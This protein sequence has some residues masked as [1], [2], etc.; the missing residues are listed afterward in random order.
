MCM[1]WSRSCSLRHVLAWAAQVIRAKAT[2]TGNLWPV[3]SHPKSSD[4]GRRAIGHW[5]RFALAI[6]VHGGMAG[7][8][9]DDDTFDGACRRGAFAQ[10]K[11]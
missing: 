11:W 10:K 3:S 7:V 6:L 9:R 2:R 5:M 1:D 4:H 8:I